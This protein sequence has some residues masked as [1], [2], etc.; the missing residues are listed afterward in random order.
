MIK[1]NEIKKFGINLI[2]ILGVVDGFIVLNKIMLGKM[3]K[4]VFLYK[5]LIKC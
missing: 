3:L 1:R 5:D 2:V 4:L